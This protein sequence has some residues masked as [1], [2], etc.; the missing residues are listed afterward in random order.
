MWKSKHLPWICLSPRDLQLENL[1]FNC[2]ISALYLQHFMCMLTAIIDKID[3]DALMVFTD[4]LLGVAEVMFW[5]KVAATGAE[6]AMN[7]IHNS[8][9][10]FVC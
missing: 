1:R 3:S 7:Y 5:H 4:M 6:S 9:W 2:L 8:F 10:P